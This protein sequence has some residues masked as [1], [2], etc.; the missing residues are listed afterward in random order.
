MVEPN[1]PRPVSGS[2]TY[3]KGNVAEDLRKAA[4]RILATERLEDITIRR[5]AR[6]VGV[7]PANFYNHY[8]SLDDL[9]F[10]IAASSLNQALDRAIVTWSGP[11]SKP[12]L[13]ICSAIQFVQFCLRNRQLMRLMLRHTTHDRCGDY[14]TASDR[15]FGEI[16]RFIY[17]ESFEPGPPAAATCERYGVAFGFIALAYGFALILTEDRFGVDVKNEAELSRFIQSGMLPFL[18]GSAAAALSKGNNGG[19]QP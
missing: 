12:D 14:Q 6:E 2:R 8:K 15:S 3:H 16:V 1:P 11:G 19:G 7:V 13:L 5:L 9:L 18:D 10:G 17:G 4:E